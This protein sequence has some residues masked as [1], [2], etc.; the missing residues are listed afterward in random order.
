M[1]KR[2]GLPN[3]AISVV[4]LVSLFCMFPYQAY[5]QALG[6]KAFSYDGQTEYY[7]DM[8]QNLK[9]IT[10]LSSYQSYQPFIPSL[11]GITD[12][13][14]FYSNTG[15]PPTEEVTNLKRIFA[16]SA[17]GIYI[18]V[19]NDGSVW[20]WGAGNSLGRIT[21][22]TGDGWSQ[23][24][25]YTPGLIDGLPELVDV[26]FG[27]GG[28]FGLDVDGQVWA[29]GRP[30]FWSTFGMTGYDRRSLITSPLKLPGLN[31]VRQIS[32]NN[33]TLG[34][35]VTDNGSVLSWGVGCAVETYQYGFTELTDFFPGHNDVKQVMAGNCAAEVLT[36]D[37]N[38]YAWKGTQG[39]PGG[40]PTNI[41]PELTQVYPG[42]GDIYDACATFRPVESMS[43][44]GGGS[45]LGADFRNID[46]ELF[47][48]DG[49]DLG[50]I[51][52]SVMYYPVADKS[53]VVG[54]YSQDLKAPTQGAYVWSQNPKAIS[55]ST[56]LNVTAS[57]SGSGVAAGEYFIGDNDPGQGNGATMTLANE[58][59]DGNGVVTS[60]D[61]TTTF[62]TNFQPGVYKISVR[63]Q[64]VAGN[65]SA[66]VSDYL[67]V[68]DPSGPN[69]TG[70][71]EVLPSLANGDILPGLTSSTQTDKANFG[72]TV[73]YGSGGVN[74]AKSDL[75]FSYD[76]GKCGGNGK[77]Q[78]GCTSSLAIN[79]TNI[80]WL[81]S[82]GQNLSHAMFQ[83]TATVVVDGIT[84]TNPFRVEV[85]DGGK[86]TPTIADR[87]TLKVYAPGANPSTDTPIYQVSGIPTKG[88]I[89]IK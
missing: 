65:W 49:T 89:T 52:L 48:A 30:F 79:A 34:F 35:A 13:N 78:S 4:Y 68:Y 73:K 33:T 69:A 71:K 87:F 9:Y 14:T 64:D 31:G 44:T 23:E 76:I 18:A 67:V 55:G 19:K 57:D 25:D 15:V 20:S 62:G 60:A 47:T 8:P 58:Q 86:T 21:Q 43:D 6:I 45:W 26:Q 82:D 80:A 36:Q 85:V 10:P 83:G 77:K 54:E 75:Q 1:A 56:T 16:S 24:D 84:T 29:W 27:A 42:C 63:A 46:G 38:V 39:G 37:G 74:T 7:N 40:G 32:I 81:V 41:A 88:K 2:R 70:N 5:A 66:P 59:T 17:T 12:E 61:L 53:L 72:F 51:G 22:D 3:V 50:N 11:V 28:V